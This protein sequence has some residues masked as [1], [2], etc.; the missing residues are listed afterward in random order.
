MMRMWLARGTRGL[1]WGSPERAAQL[2]L[3]FARA[4]RSSHYDLRA[5]ANSCKDRARGALYIL[6]ASDEARHAQLFQLRALQLAPEGLARSE[7]RADYE[8]LFERLGERDFLA[9]VHMGERRGRRQLS[10]YRDEL[11]KLGDVK[12][13]A[14]LDA[15][16]VDEL[17]HERY[18]WEQLQL[19]AGKVGAARALR[20]ARLWEAWRSW[21]RLGRTLALWFFGA[22]M[23]ALYY[24]LWPLAIIE[25]R[26]VHRSNR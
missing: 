23:I 4:E 25:R 14:L 8:Q 20:R 3:A 13:R 22:G 24:A 1:R 5:A 17:Q 11:A 16:L 9:F 15:I 21:R 2:L 12:T 19:L 7:T 26:R 6:H 18:T 10:L